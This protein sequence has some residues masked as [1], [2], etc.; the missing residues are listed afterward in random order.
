MI[1]NSKINDLCLSGDESKARAIILTQLDNDRFEEDM[2]SSKISNLSKIQGLFVDDNNMYLESDESK[3][4]Y[5]Y[6]TMMCVELSNNFSRKKLE[7]IFE[8][9]RVLRKKED[10]KFMPLKLI[11]KPSPKKPTKRV[12]EIKNND[13]FVDRF[14]SIFKRN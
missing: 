2:F 3:W 12:K 6:W 5:V 9:M 14:T 7:H 10:P 1:K 8:V 11:R 4:N 13:S